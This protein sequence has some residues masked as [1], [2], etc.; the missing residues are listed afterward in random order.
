[1]T[2]SLSLAMGPYSIEP[3]T[4][5]YVKEY[6]FL[7]FATKQERI[8][9]NMEK[10]KTNETHKSVLNLSQRLDWRRLNK[11]VVP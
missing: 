9:M 4:R 7:S 11:Y 8:Y 3:R 1:M 6:G 2:Y 10:S 5:N